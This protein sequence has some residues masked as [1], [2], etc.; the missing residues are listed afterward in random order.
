MPSRV[1]QTLTCA[2]SR[3]TQAYPNVALPSYDPSAAAF[4]SALLDPDPAGR[5]DA[6]AALALEWMALEPER[7]L[8]ER[9]WEARAKGDGRRARGKR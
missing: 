2:S 7:G 8:M 5:P 6:R 3:S 4:L 1:P 9:V